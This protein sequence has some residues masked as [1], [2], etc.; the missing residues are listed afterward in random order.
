M[1]L[2]WSLNIHIWEIQKIIGRHVRTDVIAE[3]QTPV[4]QTVL[5]LVLLQEEVTLAIELLWSNISLSFISYI[6]ILFDTAGLY[7]CLVG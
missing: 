1:I 6:F 7:S 5:G 3:D 4:C 2:W